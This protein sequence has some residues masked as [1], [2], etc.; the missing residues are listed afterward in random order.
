MTRGDAGENPELYLVD[1]GRIRRV[2]EVAAKNGNWGTK[3]AKGHGRGIA[4]HYSF[5]TCMWPR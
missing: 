5:T 3:V 1:T 2:A 4:A